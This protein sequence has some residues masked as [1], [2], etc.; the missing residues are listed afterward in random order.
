MYPCIILPIIP[1]NI[2]KNYQYLTTGVAMCT[3]KTNPD[4]ALT[5]GGVV[6]AALYTVLLDLT[7]GSGLNA[8]AQMI[9]SNFNHKLN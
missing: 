8:G 5:S 2:K 4:L 9:P 7:S 6:S 3:A 1:L